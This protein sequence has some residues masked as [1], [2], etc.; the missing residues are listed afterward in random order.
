MTVQLP[1]MVMVW[2]GA[3]IEP[4]RVTYPRGADRP[5]VVDSPLEVD[6]LPGWLDAWR[7]DPD[8]GWLG[9]VTYA[10]PVHG[11]G[12]TGRYIDWFPADRIRPSSNDRQGPPGGPREQLSR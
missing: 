3:P 6:E 9:E 5:D 12:M 1:C 8:G 7:R 11:Y 2:F 4:R 10:Y